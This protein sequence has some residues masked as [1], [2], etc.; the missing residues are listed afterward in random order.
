MKTNRLGCFS[1]TGIAAMLVTVLFITGS[2]FA[3]G[4]QLFSPGG[5]N[6]RRGA[7]LGQVSSHAEIAGKCA[8]CHTAPWSGERMADRCLAC[9]TDVQEELRDSTSL[10]GALFALKGEINCRDC[11]VEHLGENGELTPVNLKNFPHD[12]VGF[13]LA[14]HPAMWD[15]RAIQCVDCHTQGLSQ[16]DMGVCVTCHGDH[17]AA[18]M[19]KHGETFGW[20]CLNC[21]DGKET[22]GK[23]F[24]H[25]QVAFHLDGKHELLE[26]TACHQG[27]QTVAD[28]QAAPQLCINCHQQDDP[29]AGTLG[30]DCAKCHTSA[31]WE[32]IEYD[33]SLTD[34]P[35]E[36]AHGTVECE[37]CH[38]D[39]LFK[40]TPTDCAACHAADDAHQGTLGTQCQQC[41]TA[42]SWNRVNFDHNLTAFK[43]TG[44]H[45][46]AECV[47]CHKDMLFKSTPANCNACHKEDDAHEGDLGTQCEQCHTTID[48]ENTTF[49]HANAPF[50]LTGAHA[51]AECQ[52]CHTNMRFRSTPS[53]CAAC[54]GKE[55]PHA[56]SLGAN[57]AAC[58]TTSTW[59]PSTFNHN[60]SAFKLV[61]KHVSVQCSACH[62]SLMFKS[63]PSKCVSCHQKD[64]VHAG[65]LG[66]D[67][68]QCHSPAGWSQV[69]FDHSKSAFPLTGKHTSVSCTSCHANHKFKGTPTQCVA[70]HQK[71]DIHNGS[72][73]SDCKACHTTE[74]WSQVTFDHSKSAF[75]LTGA[76]TNAT[77]AKCHTGGRFKGTP[78]ACAACHAEP[79][80]HRGLFGTNCAGCHST[81][82]WRPASFNG[83]HTFPMG[84][85]GAPN[86]QTCHPNGYTSYTCY[87]CHD[88]GEVNDE[89]SDL[90]IDF[91][92]CVQCHANGDKPG[93]D[94][95]GDGDDD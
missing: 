13:S 36:G 62:N 35:L 47:D 15:G 57:C 89:H 81:S 86:C 39:L 5:L 45:Q 90:G 40:S 80:I 38:K 24:S 91:S 43:L 64:D 83:P 51:K 8:A 67:C 49:D 32:K 87:T 21:H 95:G 31:A 37:A 59:K 54:H 60:S 52:G 26:C 68:A 71:N 18:F 72:M 63:T 1:F 4:G 19:Q 79:E 30:Q 16:M 66:T 25:D 10:H 41:H 17:D 46:T 48:W 20:A 44:A 53:N 29:H 74:A 6:A 3:N 50:K 70:C 77:C 75:P 69:T 23:N 56:G 61:G 93:E 33:H 55:D 82:A 2:V 42:E 88:Q 7:T 22:L 14:A 11:H 9:H 78:T 27:A 84:H 94:G 34:F 65:A 76:H 92:N 28:L 58:H 12:V 73:G 85:G